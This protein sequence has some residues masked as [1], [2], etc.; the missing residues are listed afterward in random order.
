MSEEQKA[1]PREEFFQGM[2]KMLKEYSQQDL[3]RLR[4]IMFNE[5]RSRRQ[6]K[7]D[8][9]GKFILPPG[10]ARKV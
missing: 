5:I 10:M 3:E 2:I 6:V 8:S 7:D 4:T 9:R 1:N